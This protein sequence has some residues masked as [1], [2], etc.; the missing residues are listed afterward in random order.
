[1]TML[2]QLRESPE[3]TNDQPAGAFGVGGCRAQPLVDIKLSNAAPTRS[4]TE[5]KQLTLPPWMQILLLP[6]GGT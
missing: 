3:T 2:P 5:L 4:W 6:T 1:M